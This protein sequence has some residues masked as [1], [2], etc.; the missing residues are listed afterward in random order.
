MGDKGG[1]STIACGLE[2]HL[3]ACPTA[4]PYTGCSRRKPTP[5]CHSRCSTSARSSLGMTGG[6]TT[7]WS[8]VHCTIRRWSRMILKLLG[9]RFR[10]IRPRSSRLSGAAFQDAVNISFKR[11]PSGAIISVATGTT[12]ISPP[13]LSSSTSPIPPPEPEERDVVVHGTAFTP[14]LSDAAYEGELAWKLLPPSM[15]ARASLVDAC[16]DASN[17]LSL[18][19]GSF[20][21][22]ISSSRT[23]ITASMEQFLYSSFL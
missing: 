23:L 15:A 4:W 12:M 8:E 21:R 14:L 2:P 1:S 19:G 16:V 7:S 9:G 22:A 5:K 6:S 17:M 3:L 10:K 13:T 11:L 20:N 18:V